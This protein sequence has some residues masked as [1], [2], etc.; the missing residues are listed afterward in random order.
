MRSW[1]NEARNS[2]FNSRR[3][4]SV[5][6]RETASRR[7]GSP[8]ASKIGD[9]RTLHHLASP[10]G[11]G[12]NPTNSSVLPAAA[13]ATAARAARLSWPCQ[14]SNQDFFRNGLMSSIPSTWAPL[15]MKSK[16]PL[17]PRILMQSGLL[18]TTLRLIASLSRTASS[19]CFRPVRDWRSCSSRSSSTLPRSSA[20]SRDRAAWYAADANRPKLSS[21]RRSSASNLR[22]SSWATN[23]IAPTVLP[24]AR[25]GTSRHS[26]AKGMTG[27]KWE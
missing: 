3:R 12:K 7:S 4:C 21:C 25:K 8:S 18:S 6:L 10:F 13:A 24:L 26:C 2:R 1:L 20:A 23:Q 17:S 19:A 27:R 14:K 5:T 9:T 11:V 22:R 15:S 16:S